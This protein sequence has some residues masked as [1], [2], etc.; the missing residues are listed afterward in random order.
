M[1]R[2]SIALMVGMLLLIALVEQPRKPHECNISD[3]PIACMIRIN[4]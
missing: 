3:D 1:T 4:P 2:L